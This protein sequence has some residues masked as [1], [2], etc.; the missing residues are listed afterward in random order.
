MQREDV[1]DRILA[2]QLEW[3]RRAGHSVDSRN[4]LDSYERNLRTPLSERGQAA[5]IEGA[6]AELRDGS[7]GRPAKMR[8]LHS[9]SALAVNVFDYWLER[10]SAELLQAVGLQSDMAAIH[11]EVPLRS[12]ARGTPPHLDVL[13]RYSDGRIA[14]VES[15]FTEWMKEKRGRGDSLSPYF[16][17]T[18]DS[19]WSRAGLPLS[20]ELAIAI[21]HGNSDFQYLDAP[22]LLKHALGLKKA[23]DGKSWRIGYLFFDAEGECQA[24]HRDEIARFMLAT[25]AELGFF[26]RT[27]QEVFTSLERHATSIDADYLK[28]LRCRYFTPGA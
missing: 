7:D 2:A 25:G 21:R 26:A 19:Y 1:A 22:Q 12:G 3:A 23:A 10:D 14:G 20:H 18:D 9:S 5:F 8:A 24:R 16:R 6:G 17:D 27:Y 11:L 15:K 13:V 28:Y 4:Y